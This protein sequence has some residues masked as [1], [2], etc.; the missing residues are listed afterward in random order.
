LELFSSF[1][2]AI[3]TLVS[4]LALD[5]SRELKNITLSDYNVFITNLSGLEVDLVIISD[6]EDE[7]LINKLIPK[8][9]KIIEENKD[10]IREWDG[11]EENLEVFN[12]PLTDLIESNKNFVEGGSLVERAEGLFKAIWSHKD[13][14]AEGEKLDLQVQR[15]SLI[16]QFNQEQNLKSKIQ[17]A[18]KVIEISEELRDEELFIEYQNKIKQ[19]KKQIKDEKYKL[20]H[21]L[22]KTKESI[23][24]AVKNLGAKS[25]SMGDYKDAY[26]NLYYFS[27]KLKILSQ[28]DNWLKYKD[29]AMA[30]IDKEKKQKENFSELISKIIN[31]SDD[32]DS[33]IE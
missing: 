13:E 20:N 7:K 6:K 31:F 27:T 16:K 32:I 1:F 17:K 22:K 9:I 14:I 3:K 30:L 11:K 8:I 18:K 4:E 29:M 10:L 26:L 5:G 2:S 28:S 23:S 12:K 33:Y 15:N 21:Y 19:I 25:L 24:E